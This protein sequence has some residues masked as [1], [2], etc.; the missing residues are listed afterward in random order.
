MRYGLTVFCEVSSVNHV[1]DPFKLGNVLA[2]FVFM[3]L[4]IANS[5]SVF[6]SFPN[7]A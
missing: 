3:L 6:L 5:Q 4:F 7:K 2:P 1:S